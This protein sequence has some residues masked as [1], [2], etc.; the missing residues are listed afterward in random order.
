VELVGYEDEEAG[1]SLR[2]QSWEVHKLANKFNGIGLTSKTKNREQIISDFKN[3]KIKLLFAHPKLLGHG[4]TF[5]NCNYNI[6][7]S[8][9]FSYEEFKQSQDRIHRIGQDNKCTYIILQCKNTIDEKIY[10]CLQNKK[11]IVDELYLELG[12]TV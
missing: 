8:L 4:L 5:T 3:N 1:R 12:V 2:L 10:K 11:N 7:Y 6:Y 9:S